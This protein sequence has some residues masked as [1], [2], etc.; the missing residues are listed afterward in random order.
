MASP[1]STSL[2]IFVAAAQLPVIFE[3]K[4]I[5]SYIAGTGIAG[6]VGPGKALGIDVVIL[7]QCLQGGRHRRRNNAVTP[8]SAGELGGEE[9]W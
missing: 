6:V 2:V 7:E 9:L 5:R 4:H 1:A 8:S 3:S